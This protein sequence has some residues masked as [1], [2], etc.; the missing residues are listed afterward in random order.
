[1]YKMNSKLKFTK[2]DLEFIE[3]LDRDKSNLP[4][5]KLTKSEIEAVNDMYYKYI[6][7]NVDNQNYNKPLWANY[8][9]NWCSGARTKKHESKRIILGNLL[10][11]NHMG[12]LT[13]KEG[14]KAFLGALH[15]V[16][17][18]KVLIKE[19]YSCWS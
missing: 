6:T 4:D 5:T 18:Y 2:K 16:D 1:M 15:C 7:L 8:R 11:I 13:N 9:E 10:S 19:A 14:A 17:S 3:N 12:N